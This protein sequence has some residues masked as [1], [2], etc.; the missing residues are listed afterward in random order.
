MAPDSL[1]NGIGI[2]PKYQTQIFDLFK[3]LHS[4]S[5][6]PG[7]GVGLAICQRIA[8]RYGGTISVESSPGRGSTFTVTLA[9]S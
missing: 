3:R 8:Q 7:T 9:A 1:N 4:R 5:E 2:A 6:Y